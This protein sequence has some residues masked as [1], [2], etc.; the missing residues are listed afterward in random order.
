MFTFSPSAPATVIFIARYNCQQQV[1]FFFR[2]LF[3][4]YDK[5]WFG[6]LLYMFI[7]NYSFTHGLGLNLGEILSDVNRC[8]IHGRSGSNLNENTL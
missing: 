7:Y 4:D 5:H 1:D 3:N 6:H 2:S 8:T